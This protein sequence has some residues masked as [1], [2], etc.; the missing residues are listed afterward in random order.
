MDAVWEIL[1]RTMRTK[2]YQ[3][4]HREIDEPLWNDDLYDSVQVGNAEQ[5]ANH[6]DTECEGSI[7]EWNPIYYEETGTYWL[8]KEGSKDL[9]IVGQCQYR[10]RLKFVDQTEVEKII[11]NY[12]CILPTPLKMNCSVYQQYCVCHSSSDMELAEKIINETF[13]EY[14]EGWDAYVK[15]GRV[16]YY[17]ASY[18][19]QKKDFDEWCEFFFSF[20]EEF[21][22]RKGWNTPE[23]AKSGVEKEIKRGVRRGSRGVDYQCAVFGFLQ[24]RLLTM[25]V[26]TKFKNI[27]EIPY[28]K[29]DGV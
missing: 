29:F 17:S 28:T 2:I 19:M 9:D 21:L 15:K 8:W 14:S 4:A 20:C 10:R 27:Y 12:D 16:L 24:E 26:R 11:K 5:F 23:K 6:R 1:G 13:K 7:A 18:V 25:W 22:R 3:I